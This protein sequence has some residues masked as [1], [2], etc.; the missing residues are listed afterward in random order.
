MLSMAS[1]GVLLRSTK[2]FTRAIRAFLFRLECLAGWI[3]TVKRLSF[4]L[5]KI[6]LVVTRHNSVGMLIYCKNELH[7]NFQA[8]WTQNSLL[9]AYLEQC[10]VWRLSDLSLVIEKF[11]R[12]GEDPNLWPLPSEGHLGDFFGGRS[13]TLGY[14]VKPSTT[15]DR[16][17]V[18]F[19]HNRYTE[20][21]TVENMNAVPEC[22]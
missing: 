14:C 13:A 3:Q 9:A 1:I 5:Q 4:A 20:T 17:E 22:V 7:F 6:S 10:A 11:W 18:Y 16:D 12:T 15:D 19:C 8:S 2:I 21:L